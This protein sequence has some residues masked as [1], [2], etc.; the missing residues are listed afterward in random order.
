M[1]TTQAVNLST[2]RSVIW[3]MVITVVALIGGGP[4]GLI[5]PPITAFLA[6][7]K[8]LEG[9][10]KGLKVATGVILGVTVTVIVLLCGAILASSAGSSA[11][12][13]GGSLF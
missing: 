2:K 7:I 8:A 1:E 3:L 4:L 10:S 13:E 6:F 5:V 9:G 11:S 12:F